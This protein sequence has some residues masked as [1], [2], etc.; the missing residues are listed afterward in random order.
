MAPVAARKLIAAVGWAPV[1]GAVLSLALA[2]CGGDGKPTSDEV[3]TGYLQVAKRVRGYTSTIDRA[4]EHPPKRPDKLAREFRSF[5]RRVDYPATFLLTVPWLGPVGL[6]AGSLDH[7]LLIYEQTLREVAKRARR[8]GRG[9]SRALRGV[10]QAGAWVRADA[11]AWEAA[12]R[13]AM[14]A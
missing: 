4:T 3:K 9:L 7:S 2:G 1:A 8:D 10:R 14:A 5:A 12:L 11:A 6:K 13:A